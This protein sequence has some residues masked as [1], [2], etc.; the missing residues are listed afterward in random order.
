M[1]FINREFELQSLNAKWKDDKSNFIIVYGKRRVGKTELIKQFMKDK[2]GVYFLADKRTQHDQLRELGRLLG[3]QIGD[4]LLIK[5]GFKEWLDVFQYLKEKISRKFVFTIDEYPYLVDVDKT[6]SSIFQKGWDE[7][8]KNSKIYLI[9]SGSSISMMESETLMYKSPLYGRRTGQIYLKPLS[10]KQS[11][12]FFPKTK[13]DDFLNIY[14]ITGGMP[15]YMLQFAQK[16]SLDENI[17]LKIFNKTE[18]LFNEV[19]FMLKDGLRE[20]KIYLSILKAIAWGK[21]KFSEIIDD[22]GLEKNV[23]HKYTSTLER[24]HIIEKEVPI[25]ENKPHKSHKGVYKISDNFSRFWFHYIY[26]YKSDLEIGQIEKIMRILKESFIHLTALTYEKVC[27]ELLWE[28]KDA[29]FPFEQVGRWWGNEQE[30]DIVALNNQTK[31]I[32][33]GEVKWSNR[34]VGIHILN[35]LKNKARYVKWQIK[36]RKEYFLL[37][38]KSGFTREILDMAKKEN[39]FLIQKDILLNQ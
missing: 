4:S 10:F 12:Q 23:L 8:L 17:K 2:P 28:Y 24:L 22:T 9:I 18:F 20:P 38:S 37:C 35:E 36:K 19:E 13:M 3:E 15:A 31:E 27:Q 29:I 1:G 11:W 6:M 7:Y 26:P 16:K 5:Q 25:I 39:I 33:F 14:T 34:F 21:T 32:L 30:I